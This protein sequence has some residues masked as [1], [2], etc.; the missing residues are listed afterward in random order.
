MSEQTVRTATSA[1]ADSITRLYNHYIDNT[2]ITFEET[3]VDSGEMA[4]RIDAVTCAGLPWLVA[5][6]DSSIS[7]YAYATPFRVR[8]AYRYTVESTVYLSPDVIGKG[9]GT[10]LYRALIEHLTQAGIHAV[11]GGIALPNDASIALHERVGFHK[12]AHLEQV[13]RKFDRWIDVGYWQLLLRN[14]PR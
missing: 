14:A 9:V 13:G 12:V 8:S 3:R 5:E 10:L 6:Q 2:V 7:G 11:I 1:D 4:S